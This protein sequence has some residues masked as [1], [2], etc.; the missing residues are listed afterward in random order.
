MDAAEKGERYARIFRKAGA[1]LG[2]GETTRAIEALKEGQT[3][4]E[5]LGDRG[6]AR[7]FADEI[8]RAGKPV[9]PAD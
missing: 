9:N 2:K 3:L 6:M 8:G 7:R 4:A 1:L 5:Q